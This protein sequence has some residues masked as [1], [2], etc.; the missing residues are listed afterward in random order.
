M[1]AH[2]HI[3]SSPEDRLES[4]FRQIGRQQ[5]GP[6][7]ET[8]SGEETAP[9]RLLQ[10]YLVER[11]CAAH[12]GREAA[13][14][15][16]ALVDALSRDASLREI[17]VDLT[18]PEAVAAA[19]DTDAPLPGWLDRLISAAAAPE[20]SAPV[21]GAIGQAVAALTACI[22]YVRERWE[23]VA[24]QGLEILPATHVLTRSAGG[25]LIAMQGMVANRFLLAISISGSPA[26]DTAELHVQCQEVP[27]GGGDPKRLPS[28]SLR[29]G[30]RRFHSRDRTARIAPF[31]P[32][33][34][35]L[36]LEVMG[37]EMG[38]ISLDFQMQPDQP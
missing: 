13:D 20:G 7:A 17:F 33:R 34:H 19:T 24:C 28:F 2:D 8:D 25:Q 31:T 36:V 18:T 32:G 16:K 11:R 10:Q 15:P 12:E 38:S 29:S 27:P 22:S 5:L 21:P 14:P 4:L 37:R 30:N 1:T 3:P 23:L 26:N 35:E 6:S 9:H